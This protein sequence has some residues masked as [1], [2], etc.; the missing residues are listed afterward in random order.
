MTNDDYARANLISDLI[1]SLE[2]LEEDGVVERFGFNR[3]RTSAWIRFSRDAIEEA[4][5]G[6][7]PL[8]DAGA[9]IAIGPSSDHSAAIEAFVSRALA[10]VVA[11]AERGS[12]ESGRES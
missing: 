10:D 12:H 8:H 4:R 7:R 3:D 5:R 6:G 11:R 2:R 9:W 1:A